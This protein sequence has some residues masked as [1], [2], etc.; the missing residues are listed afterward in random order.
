M[1]SGQIMLLCSGASKAEIL[2]DA[3]TG[4]ITPLVPASALQLHHSVIV[5]AD[6]AA[7]ALL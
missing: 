2:R 4:P 7:A 5:V 1:M 3:L 6:Q